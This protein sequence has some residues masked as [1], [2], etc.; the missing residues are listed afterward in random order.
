MGRKILASLLQSAMIAFVL[1][2][3]TPARATAVLATCDIDTDPTCDPELR[4]V[5]QSTTS[6]TTLNLSTI[7]GVWGKPGSTG[8]LFTPTEDSATK[9]VGTWVL[10][11][12]ND[13]PGGAIITGLALD[14]FGH[15]QG[16]HDYSC[17]ANNFLTG[18]CTPPADTT[19]NTDVAKA[20]FITWTFAKG[21]GSGVAN[22]SVFQ[23]LDSPDGNAS[24]DK[25][26][27]RINVTTE[28]PTPSPTA[29]P[30]PAS[31]LLMG[32]GLVAIS[33]IRRKQKA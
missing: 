23:L 33:W 19:G 20:D 10:N 30:E 12:V 15:S 2:V 22:G 9:G 32:S 1:S 8:G 29:I 5:L 4:I 26:L 3:S 27:Y 16:A 28:T 17:L 7:L 18:T 14:A 6:T 13:L 25:L 24:K 11:L 31:L 21:P